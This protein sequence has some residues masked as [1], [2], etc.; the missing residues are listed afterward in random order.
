M[1]VQQATKNQKRMKKFL[2]VLAVA[3]L[4]TT[5]VFAQEE[6]SRRDKRRAREKEHAELIRQLVES[7][8]LEFIA[9]FAHPMGGSS[10]SLTSQ[11]SL[12]IRNDSVTSYL[13]FFGVAYS[14]E[15]G[16]TEGG[17][18]FSQKA[19]KM[20]W[21]TSAKGYTV[22]TEVK[23]TKDVYYLVLQITQAGYATLNV[24]SNNRQ[25]IYFTGI[26]LKPEP[27]RH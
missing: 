21:L 15:Y 12:D 1:S 8:N 3:T 27:P 4:V 19:N 10:I 7:R 14:A 9:Q 6:T 22:K 18:K 26:I 20:E 11:Y 5:V 17:I 25:A 2:F 23:T 13:P 16:N 24:N